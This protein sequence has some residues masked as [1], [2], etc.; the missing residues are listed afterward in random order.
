MALL[1][2]MPGTRFAREYEVQSLLKEGGMGAVYRVVQQS[3]GRAR[4]LKIMLPELLNDPKSRE[5]FEHEARVAARIESEHVVEVIAAGVDEPSGTPWMA[6][7]Y[8]EGQDLDEVVTARG[9]MA[10]GEASEVLLQLCDALGA[11]HRVGV[12]HCDLKPENVFVT[13][14]KGRGAGLKL[15]VLD[16]GIA[17]LV[18][19][20]RRSVQVS[21]AIGSPLFMAPEQGRRGQ[22]VRGSTDVWALGLVAFYVLTGRHYWL[23]G[24]VSAEEFDLIEQLAEVAKSELSPPSRRLAALGGASASLPAGFDAWFVRCVVRDLDARF[25]NGDEAGEALERLFV[26]PA[27]PAPTSAAPPFTQGRTAFTRRPRADNPPA[28]SPA[29]LPTQA[30]LPSMDL[31]ATVVERATPAAQSWNQPPTTVPTPSQRPVA[32]G[33]DTR[34]ALP[35]MPLERPATEIQSPPWP[36][37]SPS[38]RALDAPHRATTA[39]TSGTTRSRVWLGALAGVGALAL[40]TVIAVSAGTS[41]TQPAAQTPAPAP[42]PAAARAPVEPLPTPPV[43]PSRAEAVAA[44]GAEAHTARGQATVPTA[45]AANAPASAP[46]NDDGMTPM[47]R[48]ESCRTMSLDEPARNACTISALRGKATTDRELVFLA[49]A[50]QASGRTADAVRTMRTYIH[51]YPQGQMIANFQRYIDSHQ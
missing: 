47:Q 49:A 23:A 2:L 1:R 28:S 8:L 34:V 25:K 19:E 22:S 27:L 40:A 46:S 43:A 42:L 41:A 3:T 44:P 9:P 12:V 50:Q 48:A 16:F 4:A 20:N 30:A 11:A 17:R 38:G 5:R 35:S 45:Q 29:P 36:G 21:T 32:Q 13:R 18:Q 51:R 33:I 26:A 24:N 15:K 39:Q 10:W 6:M 7:E 31:E 37:A 14:S